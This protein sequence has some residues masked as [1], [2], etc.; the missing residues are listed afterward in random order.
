[1]FSSLGIDLPTAI[2]LSLAVLAAVLRPVDPL[3]LSIA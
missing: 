2:P 1:V 3:M